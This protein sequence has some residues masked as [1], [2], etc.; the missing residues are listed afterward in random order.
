MLSLEKTIALR[1]V[2]QGPMTITHQVKLNERYLNIFIT[3]T[4]MEDEKHVAVAIRVCCVRLLNPLVQNP[5]SFTFISIGA[6]VPC[7]AFW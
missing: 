3:Y 2:S 5:V 6:A 4:W 7:N 1:N